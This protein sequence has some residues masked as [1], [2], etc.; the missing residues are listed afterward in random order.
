MIYIDSMQGRIGPF[1]WMNAVTS[2]MELRNATYN[3][4]LH[5]VWRP[6]FSGWGDP[7]GTSFYWKPINSITYNSFRK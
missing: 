4:S 3:G 7:T 5:Y 2:K 6:G 1:W